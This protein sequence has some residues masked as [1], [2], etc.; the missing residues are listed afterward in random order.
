MEGSDGTCECN[1]DTTTLV[2]I[3]EAKCAIRKLLFVTVLAPV[4]AVGDKGP[5]W[6]VSLSCSRWQEYGSCH[7]KQ[8]PA[9]RLSSRHP[10][11]LACLQEL[12]KRLQDRHVDCAEA[13]AKK[14]AADAVSA[15]TVNP[16]APNVLQAMMKLEQANARAKTA[17]KV[18]LEAE[19]E[20]DAAEKA[21]EELKRQLQPKRPRT[22][23]D[24]GDAHEVLAEVE[25]WDLRDHRQQATR[26]QN[27]RNVQ[28]GSRQ[29]QA[30]PRAGTDGFLHHTRLGLVGWIAYWC[31]GDSA[32]AVDIIVALIKTLGLT[33]LV[34]DALATRKQKEAETNAKIVDLFKEAL[35]EIKNCRTEQQR[36]EFHIALACVMPPREAEGSK[37]G[38]IRPICDRLGLKRGK[39]SE[40]NGARPYASEQAV[41]NR[42]IFNQDRELLAQPVKVGDMVLSKGQLCELT[43]IGEGLC[44]NEGPSC[45]LAFRAGTVTQE[46]KYSTMYGIKGGCRHHARQGAHIDRKN[47]LGNASGSAL[48]SHLLQQGLGHGAHR[49]EDSAG[50]CDVSPR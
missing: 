13:L 26:V 43:A 50:C 46:H 16:D 48:P 30:K 6:Q 23:D 20:K 45:V 42:A 8:E 47:H 28:L 31:L 29:N 17:N 41:E 18:A 33:E 49:H 9:V 2:Q 32:L 34:S 14:A 37:N 39:R 3:E 27:R 4:R 7:K 1:D 40:K 36:V 15:A 5:G 21:V 44:G 12:L 10:T 24:A 25:N 35:D 19:K 22:D 38:W 11:E